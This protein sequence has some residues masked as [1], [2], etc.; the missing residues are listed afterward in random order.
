[1]RISAAPLWRALIADLNAGTPKPII[2]A[3][4]H[5]SIAHAF[6]QAAI[7]ARQATSIDRVALSGGC[8]HNRRLARLLRVRLEAEG[9]KVFRHA[10]VSPGDGGLSY[11][12]AAAAAAILNQAG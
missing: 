5:E 8:M 10:Q 4:F 3:R 9:F 6:V 1:M 11:G 7:G 12:Q 2:A